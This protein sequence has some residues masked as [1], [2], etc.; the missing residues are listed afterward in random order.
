MDLNKE[1][2]KSGL[3]QITLNSVLRKRF[4]VYR[5][6]RLLRLGLFIK[7]QKAF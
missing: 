3:R 6:R 5:D 7:A 2:V 4:L 1:G